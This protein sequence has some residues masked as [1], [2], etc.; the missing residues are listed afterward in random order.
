VVDS[1][2]HRRWMT[3]L[4]ADLSRWVL[5]RLGRESR[6]SRSMRNG[7]E[8]RIDGGVAGERGTAGGTRGSGGRD[9]WRSY[10]LDWTDGSGN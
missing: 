7:S 1:V 6:M 10:Y 9:G 4:I 3:P 2:N 8:N 5:Q